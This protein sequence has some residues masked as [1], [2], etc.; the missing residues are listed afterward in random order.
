MINNMLNEIKNEINVKVKDEDNEIVWILHHPFLF[1]SAMTFDAV[2]V[3]V[4]W[5]W[6]STRS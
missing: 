4:D 5:F 6:S 1:I 3:T 2:A